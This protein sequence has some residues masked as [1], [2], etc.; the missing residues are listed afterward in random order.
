MYVN[1][2]MTIENITMIAVTSKYSFSLSPPSFPVVSVSVSVSVVYWKVAQSL[3]RNYP[4]VSW[5]KNSL[6]TCQNKKQKQ[7][8]KTTT[9]KNNNKK[10]R[11]TVLSVFYK[12]LY[13]FSCFIKLIKLVTGTV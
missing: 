10:N 1:P 2:F 3:S 5:G 7:Q 11:E 13:F 12:V 6:N 9:T 4:V 8:Q